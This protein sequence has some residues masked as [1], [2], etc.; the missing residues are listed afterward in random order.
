MSQL[1]MITLTIS[2]F[3]SGVSII[4]STSLKPTMAFSGVRISW[5]ILAMN[6]LF[7]RPELWA[8]SVSCFS[9][10]CFLMSGV[11]LRMIP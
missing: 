10:S 4:D 2:C 3:S 9:C 8:R 11:T 7:M 6:I 5:V 1:F